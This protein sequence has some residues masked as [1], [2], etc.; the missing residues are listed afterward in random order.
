MST[1]QFKC[2]LSVSQTGAVSCHTKGQH[3][4]YIWELPDGSF[5]ALC[6]DCFDERASKE[7][8]RA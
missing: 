2:E 5:V 7:A 6:A 3:L 8:G 4:F 1:I